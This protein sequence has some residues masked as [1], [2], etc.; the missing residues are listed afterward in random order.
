MKKNLSQEKIFE[1]V[2]IFKRYP[3]VM[4][5]AF[6]IIGMPEDT[7]ETL[8]STYKLIQELDIHRPEI[9]NLVPFP[10]NSIVFSINI[11]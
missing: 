2:K 4:I 1:V 5:R 6:F 11:G 7:N 8:N 3:Q 10:W 9:S